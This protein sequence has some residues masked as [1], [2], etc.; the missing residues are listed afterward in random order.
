MSVQDRIAEVGRRVS[1]EAR[2]FRA[3]VRAGM[4]GRES[5]KTMAAIGKAI[6]DYGSFASASRLAALRHGSYPA[7]ADDRGEITFTEFDDR[8]NQ[9]RQRAA[10]R[11]AS[12]P[13]DAR[14]GCMCR[15]HRQLLIASFGTAR[16]GLRTSSSSTPSFS[17]RQ[18]AEVAEREGV[19]LL[20]HDAE[21]AACRRRCQPVAQGK[22]A[23]C[24][25]RRSRLPTSSTR[26]LDGAPARTL[27]PAP[28]TIRAGS[29]CSPAARPGTPKG[30]RAPGSEGLH[31]RGLGARADADAGSRGDRRRPS[32]LPRHRAC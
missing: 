8:V 16:A 12:A 23:V 17:A 18:C 5:P 25:D 2:G 13:R 3:L 14:S 20:I 32:A 15:N 31:R 21:L 6:R 1:W 19:A 9:P 24:D 30:A 4:L 29:S 11:R 26:L 28:R 7:I 10:S 22:R 27:P